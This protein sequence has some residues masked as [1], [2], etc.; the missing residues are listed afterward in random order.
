MDRIKLATEQLGER[1]REAA[2]EVGLESAP[3]RVSDDL[4]IRYATVSEWFNG[5]TVPEYE[6]LLK[7]ADYFQKKG[8]SPLWLL[9]D[10]GPMSEVDA[11][12]PAVQDAL[13]RLDDA[14]RELRELGKAGEAGGGRGG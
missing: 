14:L 10:Q 11:T 1:L 4:G 7:L 5:K 3:T 12:E 6:N 2:H 9:M 13:R 8:V